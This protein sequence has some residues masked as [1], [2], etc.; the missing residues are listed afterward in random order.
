MAKIS[1]KTVLKI[2]VSIILLAVILFKVDKKQLIQ[3]ISM[4]NPWFIPLIVG[5]IVLNYFVSSVRWKK[6]LIHSDTSHVSVKYLTSLY[7]IG[8]FFNNFMPTSVG[9]DVYKVVKLGKKLGSTTDAF[10]ATFME[11]FTGVAALVCISS[12][13]LIKL[14][15]LWGVLIFL[16]VLA[17]IPIGYICLG[18]ASKKIKKLQKIY[19][20][21]SAYRKSPKVLFIAFLTSFIVQLCSIFAQYF[22]FASVGAHFSPFYAL[23]IFPLIIL[24]S[25]FIPSINGIGVQDALYIQ[26]IAQPIP[27]LT[28]DIALSASVLFHLLRLGVSLVGGV[29]YAFNKD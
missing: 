13:A 15:G 9:G 16:A 20:S 3:N 29:L 24:A 25:F 10:T 11:R 22:V 26:L 4:M 27:G 14:L 12:A 17:G 18:F 8:S 28:A 6:L 19:D 23:F 5:L 21:I 1:K 7:F 2:A